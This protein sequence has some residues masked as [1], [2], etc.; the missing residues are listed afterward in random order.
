MD[1]ATRIALS[2]RMQKIIYDQQ[3]VISLYVPYRK[4]IVHQ[5]WGNAYATTE[6]PNL[7]YQ[8]MKLIAVTPQ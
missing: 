7:I 3:P 8:N 4:I 5:R 6:V 2:R 1:E